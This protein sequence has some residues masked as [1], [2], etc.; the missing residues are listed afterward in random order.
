MIRLEHL[1]SQ[2]KLPNIIRTLN[3]QRLSFGLRNCRQ[4]KRRENC[5]DGN[6]HQQFHQ[7]ECGVFTIALAGHL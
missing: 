1:Q 5:D 6:D 2:S 7:R 4:Q 3:S